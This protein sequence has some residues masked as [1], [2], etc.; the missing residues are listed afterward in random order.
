[1]FLRMV[2]GLLAGTVELRRGCVAYELYGL[3]RQAPRIRFA[4]RG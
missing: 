3:P 1:M 2:Y 4:V